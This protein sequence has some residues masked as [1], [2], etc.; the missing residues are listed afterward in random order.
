MSSLVRWQENS[1]FASRR[2]GL[3]VGACK[4]AVLCVGCP[5]FFQSSSS[6]LSAVVSLFT[7][8][9]NGY[10]YETFGIS[11]HFPVKL[12]VLLIRAE[13]LDNPLT[14]KCFIYDVSRSVFI[15]YAFQIYSSLSCRLFSVHR[16][17]L[18][19]CVLLSSHLFYV[20]SS[21]LIVC[22]LLYR[23]LW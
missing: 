5:F 18:Y 17:G 1:S 9:G 13:T 12:Q 23:W 22:Q 3:C 7:L 20:L 4:C 10:V 15:F 14:A 11:K 21:L 19:Y 2:V 8:G 16:F 6:K